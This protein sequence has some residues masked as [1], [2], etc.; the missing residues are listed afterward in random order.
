MTRGT[1][2]AAAAAC[3]AVLLTACAPS[4]PDD[5]PVGVSEVQP[6]EEYTYVANPDPPQP[7]AEPEE[8][9]QGFLAAGVGVQDDYA[10]AREYLTDE[11]SQA[12]VPEQTTWIH[13]Q[14]PEI[15]ARGE[16]AFDMSVVVDS[17][18][19]ESGT[20]TRPE[21]V[22]SFVFEL[23]QQDG[24]WRIATPPE[25]TV[26]SEDAFN[27]AYQDLTL[28]FFDPELRYA[29]PDAR[30]FVNQ[31]GLPAEI[32]N[33]LVAGPAQWLS[34]AVVSAFPEDPELTV[35]TDVDTETQTAQVD[36]D[37]VMASGLDDAELL[38]IEEQLT[39]VLT[40][41]QGVTSVEITAGSV[42]L[43]IPDEDEVPTED[44]PDIEVNPVTSDTQVGILEG[45]LAR[46]QGTTTF[47]AE[48]VPELNEYNPRLPATPAAAEG[49]VFAFVGDNEDGE[50][51]LFH[52]RPE[53]EAPDEVVEAPGMTRP[54]MDNFG[55][56]WVAAD[57]G[58]DQ[59]I[60][61][62]PYDDSAGS[63]TQV[64][65]E[66]LEGRTVTSMR[67]A[68]DGTRAALVVDD[69]GERMVVI[70]PVIR[71]SEG[72]P[73][74]LGPPLL[75]ED[76]GSMDE[77]R[78]SENDAVITWQRQD[79]DEPVEVMSIREIQLSGEIE[80]YTSVAGLL[81]VSA[82]E[83]QD[84]IYAENPDSAYY[85]LIGDSWQPNANVDDHQIEIRD[86]A[87]PG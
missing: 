77:V 72:V 31:P 46:Q 36:L 42:E 63:A 40:Q 1:G 7:G 20:M 73:R 12:W 18:V 86:Y 14:E 65:A 79:P 75:L 34:E 21:A 84:A 28:Y 23:E 13:T 16:D 53:D 69:A 10:V 26:L 78:W 9:I 43:D 61:A 85:Q 82:G 38:L 48:G 3:A 27:N 33:E 11:A 8:I 50:E 83:G 80:E 58:D 44:R 55:W 25:G 64:S 45:E 30:W 24:Q 66:W 62:V 68:Q 71:N 41:L 57:N 54:S 37:P 56:T 47:A 29:V 74:L 35:S 17:R 81:N 87:Y 5:G 39:L 32:V 49:E 59:V 67:I 70:A 60:H 51:A 15:T 19:D 22:E 52:V 6:E 4:V 76:S 2:L